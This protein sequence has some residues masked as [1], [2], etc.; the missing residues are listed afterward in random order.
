MKNIYIINTVCLPIITGPSFT[1][2]IR[3]KFLENRGYNVTLFYPYLLSKISQK[4][5]YGV[6]YEKNEFIK[7]LRKSYT[8]S[9]KINI[10]LYNTKYDDLCKF[11]LS[12]CNRL[13][14]NIPSNTILF[15]EDPEPLFV[16]NPLL[17]NLFSFIYK[18]I[19]LIFHTRYIDISRREML[20]ASKII[21]ICDNL[22]IKN[23]SFLE[24]VFVI[25]I[26]ES[27]LY[28]HGL[29]I[30]ERIYCEQIHGINDKYYESSNNEFINT[31]KLYFIG[32]IQRVH[33]CLDMLLE[34]VSHA[35]RKISIFGKGDDIDFIQ[36]NT[37]TF[38]Y[39]GLCSSSQQ[40]NPYSIYVSCSDLEGLCTAT[41]EAIVMNKICVIR[42][43][44][45][46]K[47]FEKYKNVFF[48]SNKYEFKKILEQ[49]KDISV[50]PREPN[51]EDF[52]WDVCNNN[53]M[54]VCNKIL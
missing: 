53:L 1:G 37:Q 27:L 13:I 10:V 41:A 16:Y 47:V 33:K 28:Q 32:K 46:N 52:K 21:K 5:L 24:N 18:R 8:L 29:T 15:I 11:Q 43:C 30:N 12:I 36:E 2:S 14:E 42:K 25:S 40:L 48:F 6:T 50:I 51:A 39:Q 34:C 20:I 22:W 31:N 9:P 17:I 23:M 19:I 49:I 26:N 54:N 4:S 3:A 7:Y 35:N 38:E 45:C 44:L